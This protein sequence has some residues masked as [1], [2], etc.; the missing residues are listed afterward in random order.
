MPLLSNKLQ[1]GLI[2]GNH[3]PDICL[4]NFVPQKFGKHCAPLRGVVA[5]K[6]EHLYINMA[7]TEAFVSQSIHGRGGERVRNWQP[8][9]G[10]RKQKHGLVLCP[11]LHATLCRAVAVCMHWRKSGSRNQQK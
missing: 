6:V 1:S 8:V 10:A 11:A 9:L 4:G 5:H 2:L 7:E 3:Q